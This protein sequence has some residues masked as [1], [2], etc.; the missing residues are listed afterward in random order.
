MNAASAMTNFTPQFIFCRLFF[1]VC[2]S[3]SLLRWGNEGRPHG[4]H[5]PPFGEHTDFHI[6]FIRFYCLLWDGEKKRHLGGCA[7]FQFGNPVNHTDRHATI[8]HLQRERHVVSGLVNQLQAIEIAYRTVVEQLVGTAPG[9]QQRAV[10]LRAAEYEP[11]EDAHQRRQQNG[12]SD[13]PCI[14]FLFFRFTFDLIDRIITDEVAGAVELV[15]YGVAGIDASGAAHTFHLQTIAD[16]DARGAYLHAQVAVYAIAHRLLGAFLPMSAGFAT[17][18]VVRNGDAFI[19]HQHVLSPSVRTNG[20]TDNFAQVGEY[21]V[22]HKGKHHD[23]HQSAD[24]LADGIGHDFPKGV[25]PD[26]IREDKVGDGKGNQEENPMFQALLHVFGGGIR[27][28]VQL[29]LLGPIAF[30]PKFNPAACQ[31]HEDG[32]RAGPSAPYA[33]ING[34]KQYDAYQRDQHAEH[35]DVEV[36]GP[37]NVA[38]QDELA[39]NDIEQ[40]EWLAT[41]LNKGGSE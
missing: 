5:Q 37:E 6:G 40:E 3:Q 13:R 23:R 4:L 10:D 11:P 8:Q 27:T 30:D 34:G 20:G 39:L 2:V 29:F 33:P 26:D 31:P 36:L 16:I 17:A 15:H 1:A 18:M 22:E 25:D 12:V 35:K 19:V 32:L 41:H 9:A 7:G 38:E 28:V 21:A 24:M 14:A